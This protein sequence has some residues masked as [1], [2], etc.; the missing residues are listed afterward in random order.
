MSKVTI[1]GKSVDFDA[2]VHLMD[3]E[4]REGLNSTVAWDQDDPKSYQNFVNAYCEAHVT[5][6]GEDFQIA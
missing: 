3:D 1:S 6:F 2:A 5:K 4:L